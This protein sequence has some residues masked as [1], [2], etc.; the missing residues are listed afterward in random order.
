MKTINDLSSCF[1]IGMGME[2][3]LEWIKGYVAGE[4]KETGETSVPKSAIMNKR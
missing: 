1:S 3:K 2:A 4:E